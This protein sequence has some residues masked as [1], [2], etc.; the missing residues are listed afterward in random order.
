MVETPTKASARGK[1]IVTEIPF[2]VN[3]SRLIENIARLVQ[4]KKIEGI[5]DIRDESDKEGMRIVIELKRDEVADIILNQLYKHTAMQST[6]GVIM[7]ALVENQPRVLSLKQMLRAYLDHRIDVV[8]RRTLFD[9]NKA[10]ERAHILEGL[11]IALD[12]IDKVIATIRKSRTPDEAREALVKK[13]A[14]TETQAKAIL[15]MRLQRLTGLER[16]K[17]DAEYEDLLK[18]MARLRAI[19]ESER[20]LMGVI[21]AELKEIRKKY[22]DERR[23]EILSEEGEFRVEDFIA[24]EDMVITISHGGYLKRLAVSTYRKQRRGGKG[25]TGMETK[26]EDFVEYIFIAS[27]HDYILF[28]TDRGRVHWLKVHEIPRAGRYSKGRAMVNV[29]SLAE[30]E[31]V[32]AFLSVKSFEDDKYVMMATEKGI[33]KKTELAAFSNPRSGGIIAIG[34]AE[35]DKLSRVKLTSGADEVLLGAEQGLALRFNEKQVRR[36]GRTARGV[37]GIR[38]EEGDRLIGMEVVRAEA[39]ILVVTENGYGKRTKF[40][41]Y[42]AQNRGGKGIINVKTS[43]RNGRCIGMRTVRE[44]EEVVCVSSQGKIVRSPVSGISLI[45]RNTQGVRV[46]RLGKDDSFVALAVVMPREQEEKIANGVEAAT[47]A[48][49]STAPDPA[50]A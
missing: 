39:T 8:T 28:F 15:E 18:E 10:E 25:V 9:L 33:V 22:G 45:G 20:V 38:L 32:A 48:E 6:F 23:T 4:E 27:T 29:L 17:I 49:T 42:R 36:M 31:N 2:Q 40:D 19:L 34:L 41:E 5:S 46:M 26:E 11:K 1:I 37:I 12:N 16:E 30:G 44:N 13:F 47:E 24:E 50:E 14:L 21:R 43:K 35:G 3:K 7:L